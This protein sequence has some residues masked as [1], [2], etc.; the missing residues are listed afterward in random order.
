[1]RPPL[2]DPRVAAP[3]LAV[4]RHSVI[5]HK[6]IRMPE[7][8]LCRVAPSAAWTGHCPSSSCL[9]VY[10]RR[11][12]KGGTASNYPLVPRGIRYRARKISTLRR[13]P[14]LN[15]IKYNACSP[16]SPSY[17]ARPRPSTAHEPACTCCS[18]A[19]AAWCQTLLRPSHA[20]WQQGNYTA[21]SQHHPATCTWTT[22]H[23]TTARLCVLAAAAPRWTGEPWTATSRTCAGVRCGACRPSG[24][25]TPTALRQYA[26]EGW[27]C[28]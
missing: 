19:R 23:T 25:S 17:A 8:F 24:G 10:H 26:Y 5:T 4:G 2:H 1:M 13:H 14:L 3:P 15:T 9:P 22:A 6:S 21:G 18:V 16:C 20:P 12:P 7:L 27:L 28:V 11:R